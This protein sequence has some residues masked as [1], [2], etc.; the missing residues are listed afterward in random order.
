[1]AKQRDPLLYRHSAAY[2]VLRFVMES[3][4]KKAVRAL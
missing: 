3:H 2:G 4:K 1:M